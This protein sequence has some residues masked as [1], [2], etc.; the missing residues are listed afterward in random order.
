MKGDSIH[1]V[2]MSKRLEWQKQK[3]ERKMQE[4][5]KN[6]LQKELDIVN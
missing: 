1:M 2:P 6:V 5:I 4:K 3:E